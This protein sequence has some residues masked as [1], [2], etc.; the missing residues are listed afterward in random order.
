MT[1]NRR[2]GFTAIECLVVFAILAVLIAL[3]LPAINQA[4]TTVNLNELL[5]Q[6]TEAQIVKVYPDSKPK[7][8]LV[9]ITV[10][11]S[12][13][14]RIYEVE[15]DT[16]SLEEGDVIIIRKPKCVVKVI[17]RLKQID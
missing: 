2:S 16:E 14:E 10:K 13:V 5:E 17:K 15:D 3:I 12:T 6:G 7:Q 4:K 9:K 8:I 1:P 11:E